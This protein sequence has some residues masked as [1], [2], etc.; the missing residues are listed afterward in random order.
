MDSSGSVLEVFQRQR[1]IAAALVMDLPLGPDATQVAGVEFAAEANSTWPLNRFT[2]NH[3]LVA[4]VLG[5]MFA[6][7]TT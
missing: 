1:E 5:L 7:G 2:D 6:G 3:K 4:A